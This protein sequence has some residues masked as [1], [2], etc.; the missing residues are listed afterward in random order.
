MGSMA[1]RDVAEQGG[2]LSTIVNLALRDRGV[3]GDSVL[4]LIQIQQGLTRHQIQL[5]RP[6][7]LPSHP[8]KQVGCTQYRGG[9]T[10]SEVS[11]SQGLEGKREGE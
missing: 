5:Q 9:T 7:Q 1:D 11:G 2:P 10:T 3:S 4:K 8:S 6:S